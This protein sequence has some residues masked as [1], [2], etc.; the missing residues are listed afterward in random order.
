MS[1]DDIRDKDLCPQCR[2]GSLRAW[3]ELSDEEREVARRLPASVDYTLR[4]RAARHRWCV[5]CWHEEQDGKM[6][7]EG[8][9]LV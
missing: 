5:R 4:E 9:T 1:Y 3:S 7:D 6:K 2:A 8:G